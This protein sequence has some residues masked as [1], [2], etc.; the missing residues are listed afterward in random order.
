MGPNGEIHG[1]VVKKR[2]AH[3]KDSHFLCD[4]KLI[5]IAE[6]KIEKGTSSYMKRH[7]VTVGM[8]KDKPTF[9]INGDAVDIKFKPCRRK[10]VKCKMGDPCQPCKAAL[11]FMANLLKSASRRRLLRLLASE[12]DYAI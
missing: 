7:R 11:E 2:T 6:P 10:E 4:A 5:V 3:K 12:A 8:I 9:K 1:C